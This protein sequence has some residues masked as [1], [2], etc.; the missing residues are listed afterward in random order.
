MIFDRNKK[1]FFQDFPNIKKSLGN[2]EKTIVRNYFLYAR[3]SVDY[4]LYFETVYARLAPKKKI[5][6]VPLLLVNARQDWSTQSFTWSWGKCILNF[7]AG[8]NLY[9]LST[10]VDRYTD[11]RLEPDLYQ[12]GTRIV[13]DQY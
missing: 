5:V 9:G 11:T 8:Y 1:I 12:T 4:K 7:Q 10:S 2:Q 6:Y 3:D 13:L